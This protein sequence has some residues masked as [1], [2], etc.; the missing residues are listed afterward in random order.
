MPGKN[1]TALYMG[2]LLR[3]LGLLR[4]QG[5][6]PKPSLKWNSV[7]GIID[8]PINSYTSSLND[9]LLHKSDLPPADED[10]LRVVD[11]EYFKNK[12]GE[13]K[14]IYIYGGSGPIVD[15]ITKKRIPKRLAAVLPL[16]VEKLGTIPIP[17]MLVPGAPGGLYLGTTPVRILKE[18]NILKEVFT[19]RYPFVLRDASLSHGKMKMAMPL[20]ACRVPSS[21]ES[22]ETGTYGSVCC[23]ILG[24][25]ALWYFPNLLQVRE[26]E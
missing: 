24:M 22:E 17:F 25:E 21:H 16:Q 10:F 3:G 2:T 5:A 18:L 13:A 23:N 8:Y 14:R 12:Y 19:T 20:Y 7:R 11:K 4:L 15:P 1:S 6:K 26:D 9:I